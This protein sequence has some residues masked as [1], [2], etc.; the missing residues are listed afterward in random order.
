MIIY[1]CPACLS[2]SIDGSDPNYFKCNCCD[3]IF[4]FAEE[5]HSED[6][7]ESLHWTEEEY[8]VV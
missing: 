2:D 7:E 6:L 8:L 5:I 3:N 1:V 4:E